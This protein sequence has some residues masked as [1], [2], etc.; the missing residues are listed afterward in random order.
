[1]S[2]SSKIKP[3]RKLTKTL[4]NWPVKL[5]DPSVRLLRSHERT[6]VSICTA[7]VWKSLCA[8]R[9]EL[10]FG[11]TPYIHSP[12][13]LFSSSLPS[14]S[15][16]VLPSYRDWKPPLSSSSS[17]LWYGSPFV[18]A[19]TPYQLIVVCRAQ[20]S[21][22]FRLEMSFHSYPIF[23]LRK[24]LAQTSS[25][26]WTLCLRLMLNQPRA[27]SLTRRLFEVISGSR[28]F[29]SD[30]PPDL[31]SACCA[32]FRS[33]SNPVHI[34]HWLEPVVQARVRRKTCFEFSCASLEL[35]CAHTSVFN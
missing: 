1:M 30:T 17:D 5:L 15:G 24:E 3:T 31:V 28:T 7:R 25:S 4:L 2:S 19:F 32:T 8:N 13:L 33:R 18:N 21:E 34:L 29:T 11:V 23:R 20:P 12:N 26:C 22:P 35:T 27:R 10:P 9:I 16:M 14:S 6:T